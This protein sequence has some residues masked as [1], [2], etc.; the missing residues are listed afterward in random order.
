[1]AE[2]KGLQIIS[3]RDRAGWKAW[4]ATHGGSPGVWLK[5]AK[6]AKCDGRWE[7]A[8]APQREAEIPDDFQ[9]ALDADP[10]VKA[11]FSTLKGVKRYAILY[12]IYNAETEKARSARIGKFVAMLRLG[13]SRSG[14]AC[15]RDPKNEDR[16]LEKGGLRL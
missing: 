10:G 12:R 15:R 3:L 14:F 13:R 5:F 4:L 11:F 2:H 6:K 7:A 8:Y 9:T 1:M 16:S